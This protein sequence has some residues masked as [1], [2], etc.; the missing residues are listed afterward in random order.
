[1]RKRELEIG[2]QELLDVRATD[3]GSLLDL[4]DAEDL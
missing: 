3:I 2:C 4:N 1:V